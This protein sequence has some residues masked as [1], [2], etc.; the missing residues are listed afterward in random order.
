MLQI[1]SVDFCNKANINK[2]NRLDRKK[3]GLS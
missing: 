1:S 2:K 3:I